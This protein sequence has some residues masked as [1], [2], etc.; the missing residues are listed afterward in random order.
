LRAVQ[1]P[2]IFRKDWLMQAHRKAEAERYEGTDDASVVR[3]Y[4][5]P[6]RLV[7]GEAR[8]FKMTTPVD[9]QLMAALL[10]E[11][12]NSGAD[13]RIPRTGNGYDVHAL[14]PDRPLILC[15]ETIPYEKGLLGHS[16]ADVAIHA[17][18]DALLG[19]ACLG[20]I[21]RLFPDKDPAYKG[22]SSMILLENVRARLEETRWQ[23]VH[24]DI[25]IVAQRPKLAAH[26]P[27]MRRNIAGALRI[28][29]DRVSVKGKTTEGLGFEGRG[30]GIS[31]IAT[32]TL[33]PMSR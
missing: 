19:A 26:V 21:G 1:T 33:I 18:I 4:G 6:V 7:E 25:T 9:F 8:N 27:A 28:A 22:I 2:Q 32:A 14:V 29:E 13:A 3:W 16:D 31:A 23:I 30:E 10:C 24:A 11:K 15:G 17:L 12:G 20:D 5:K